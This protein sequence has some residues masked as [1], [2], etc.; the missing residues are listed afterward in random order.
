MFRKIKSLFTPWS[1]G[2]LV[3]GAIGGYVYYALV[4]CRGDACPIWS[5]PWYSIGWG[6]L[7]GYLL[8]GSFPVRKAK[9]D[10]KREQHGKEE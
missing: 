4:G 2:G 5:N 3:L 7:F 10:Q 9:E 6:A 8:G 1:V